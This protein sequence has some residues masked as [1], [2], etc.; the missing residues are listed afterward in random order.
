MRLRQLELSRIFVSMISSESNL[1]KDAELSSLS[2]NGC[3]RNFQ[4][5][6]GIFQTFRTTG[7]FRDFKGFVLRIMVEAIRICH[8]GDSKTTMNVFQFVSL[9]VFPPKLFSKKELSFQY[10]LARKRKRLFVDHDYVFTPIKN[11]ATSNNSVLLTHYIR[12]AKNKINLR[13]I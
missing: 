3:C 12:W 5:T 9:R 1:A 6:I 8:Q 7:T 11:L 13:K 4:R 10:T 2:S